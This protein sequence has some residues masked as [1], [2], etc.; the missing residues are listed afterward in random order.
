MTSLDYDWL[1][2]MTTIIVITIE[3]STN[4]DDVIIHIVELMTSF[5]PKKN[6]CFLQLSWIIF[7]NKTFIN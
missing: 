7:I 2:Y 5:I 3:L 4:N 6:I 1:A